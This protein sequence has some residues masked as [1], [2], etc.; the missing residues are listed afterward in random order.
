[1]NVPSR[2]DHESQVPNANRHP[3][4]A[5]ARRNELPDNLVVQVAMQSG[6]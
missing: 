2:R 3:E 5:G 4:I 1:M 6:R